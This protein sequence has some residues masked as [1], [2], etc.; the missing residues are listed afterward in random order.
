MNHD[1]LYPNVQ[2]LPK[3]SLSDTG[4]RVKYLYGQIIII[5]KLL[6]KYEE[7]IANADEIIHDEELHCAMLKRSKYPCFWK[8]KSKKIVYFIIIY[9]S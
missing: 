7:P 4:I 6:R 5:I 1:P 8:H 3:L 2:C 9:Y